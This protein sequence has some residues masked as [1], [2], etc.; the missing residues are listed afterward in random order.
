M[1][2]AFWPNRRVL[3]YNTL[4]PPGNIHNN[5][6]SMSLN[7]I[8]QSLKRLLRES[9][10]V[11]FVLFKLMVP[12]II[13]V[14]VLQEMGA[15]KYVAAVLDP[16]M[17]LTG[18]PGAMG[19]VWA[20]TLLTNLYAGLIIFI[21]LLP[22]NPVSTAQAT[23]LASMMLIAHGLPVE[24]LIA[25]KA[26]ARIVPMAVIRLSGALLYG[27]ILNTLYSASNYLQQP[28]R[29]Y[30]DKPE[31]ADSLVGWAWGEIVGLAEIFV[32]ITALLFLMKLLRHIGVTALIEKILHPVLRPL[33]IG[34]TATDT[35]I[36][37]MTLGI[38]YGGGLII[39]DAQSGKMPAKDVFFSLALMGL[40]HSL[41]E[42]TLVML[43]FGAH[44]SGILF[45]RLLFSVLIVFLLVRL[46]GVLPSA[47]F[48]RFLYCGARRK[49]NES[50]TQYAASP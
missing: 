19:I 2:N 18:L 34:R 27:G 45:G 24:L 36:V 31:T 12:V 46:V 10:G 50:D 41:I 40:S 20:T 30:W 1:R 33:G 11:S 14:K 17:N 35:T 22:E 37:A 15:V 28:V 48:K 32:I 43:A 9:C 26:G 16:L 42:D 44:I 25:R 4:K 13:A 6:G 23:V 38:S 5:D 8:Y 49:R 21:T 39:R 47:V 29:V 7:A 3:L